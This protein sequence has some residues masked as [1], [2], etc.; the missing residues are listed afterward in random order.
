MGPV[1]DSDSRG[2]RPK[3]MGLPLVGVVG[4]TLGSTLVIPA[5]WAEGEGSNGGLQN[6]GF[7]LNKTRNLARLSQVWHRFSGPKAQGNGV[8]PSK[9]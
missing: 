5:S 8:T 1:F 9:R 4:V 7:Y 6:F 3:A 2:V